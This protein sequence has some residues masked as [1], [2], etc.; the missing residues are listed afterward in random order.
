[1]CGVTG[2]WSQKKFP[3][4]LSSLPA[5]TSCLRHR[6]PD[7]TGYWTDAEAGVAFGHT[8]LS[9]VDLSAH[10]HQPMVSPTGRYVF[11]FNG[12]IYNHQQIR[13]ELEEHGKAPRWSGHSDTETLLAAIDEWG[14]RAALKRC[15]GMFAFAIWNR[16]TRELSLARD[17]LGEKPL[18]YGLQNGILLFGSELKSLR[19]GPGFANELNRDSI[20]LLLRYG[21]IPGPHSVYRGIRKLPPGTIITVCADHLRTSTLPECE[22]Y[23]SLS[24]VAR[25]G[26]ANPFSG[27]EREAAIALEALLSSAVRDQML[28]DVPLGAFLSGGVD[29]STV[30]ALMQ[31]QSARPVKTFTIGFHQDGYNEASYAEAVAA[32]LKTEHT[33]LY[34]SGEQALETI[35]ALPGLYD[36]PFADPSQIPTFLV[37]KLARAHVT[38]SLSGDGGDELFGGYNRY[39]LANQLRRFIGSVPHGLRRGIGRSM[40][41]VA[42]T[43]WDSWFLSVGRL[44]AGAKASRNP[45]DKIHKLAAALSVQAP[46]EIYGS[47]VSFWNHPGAVTL[48][49]HEPISA[50]PDEL[51]N[52]DVEDFTERMMYFDQSTYLPD[53][54]L[55]K[56]DR[57]AMGVSL[58]TRMPFLDHRLVEFSWTLPIAMK[59]RSGETKR[60]LRRVL[61][62]HVPRRLIDRPKAGFGVPLDRWL[63]GPLREWAEAL[64]DESRLRQEAYFNPVPI[65]LRW[66]EHLNGDRNWANSLWN[67]LMFQS[68]L[69]NQQ[70]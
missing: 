59:V 31:H 17:R 47:L 67:V 64:L 30:V 11:V 61:Y 2:G 52:V 32:H 57:A 42:P 60:V 15:T 6:G 70:I 36:E 69:E 21:Y 55:V 68:W 39:A 27:D 9:I 40:I 58:E 45:G 23:W 12:E 5:M 43:S 28:A 35:P 66:Q 26:R 7:D 18:Y 16:S 22:T 13:R 38:V 33:Q 10:G 50:F 37:A 53:D 3:D 4:L 63:R 1:M 54:I 29:S 62:E 51:S 24:Q 19:R 8:R 41:A 49:A 44:F 46:D 20:A 34:V 25:Q 56:V 65:R 14:L 48:G